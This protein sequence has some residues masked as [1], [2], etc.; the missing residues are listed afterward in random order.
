MD[1]LAEYG[2]DSSSDGE[3]HEKQQDALPYKALSGL[4]GDVPQPSD[5]NS[6]REKPSNDDPRGTLHFK[7]TR[8]N[9][10]SETEH[11]VDAEQHCAGNTLV[12]SSV[13]QT[14]ATIWSINYLA[15]PIPQ[16]EICVFDAKVPS[17][18]ELIKRIQRISE[19]IQS[20]SSAPESWAD[21][22]RTQQE[23]HNP[24]FF[25]S[26]V[27]R[28]GIQDMLGNQLQWKMALPEVRE[29]EH[30]QFRKKQQQ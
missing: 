13:E 8:L 25:A 3:H 10:P 14:F 4:L 12:G 29:Y 1:V 24:R 23:F 16:K 26:A 6:A 27:E 28:T 17:Q 11:N 18:S 21:Y 22:L 19:K 5:D 2:S 7:R 30:K 9:P 15:R 20:S